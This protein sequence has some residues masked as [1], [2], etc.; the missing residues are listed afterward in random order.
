MFRVR[1]FWIT[2][3]TDDCHTWS[4]EDLKVWSMQE[5]VSHLPDTRHSKCASGNM[6]SISPRLVDGRPE[7]VSHLPKASVLDC[8]IQV[9]DLEIRLIAAQLTDRRTE[10]VAHLPAT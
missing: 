4:T 10:Q 7:R 6:P 3:V 9:P 8:T 5:R 1:T 2:S